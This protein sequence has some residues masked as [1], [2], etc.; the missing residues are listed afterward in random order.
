MKAA[1]IVIGLLGLG[2]AIFGIFQIFSY[3][4]N[5]YEPLTP[6]STGS[7]YGGANMILRFF[8]VL[9]GFIIFLACFKKAFRKPE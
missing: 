5:S 4:I 3:L 8:V 9:V 2:M 6:G 1:L 7:T